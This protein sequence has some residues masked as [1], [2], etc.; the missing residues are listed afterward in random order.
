MLAAGA[1]EELY[2]AGRGAWPGIHADAEAFRARLEASAEPPT[3]AA[4]V[5]L[6][7][8]CAAGDG[9]A[10]AAFEQHHFPEVRRALTRLRIDGASA[11]DI[12]QRVRA[13]VLVGDPPRIA[14]YAG[15]GSLA[16]W[17]R[18]IAV[19]EALTAM[20]AEKRRGPHEGSSA[21]ERIAAPEE[22]ELAQLRARYAGP[23]K[24]AFS[25]A[26]A[27]LGP[28]DRNVLRLTYLEG[29]TAEQIGLAYGVHRVS[30]ARWLSQIRESL[31]ERT[32]ATLRER[33]VL[34]PAE[35]ESVTRL[36]LS[37]IDVSL[38]RLL[39]DAGDE[40]AGG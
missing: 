11:D 34:G 20:R 23:F 8:A 7:V 22:P 17:L 3:S 37:Q 14:T 25:D 16:A 6:A 30:V 2:E 31:F 38:D 18:A 32:H 19:H 12:E 15:R 28:R 36:C 27:S 1:I 21:I 40:E 35:L 5:Y 33:L 26:L 24:T 4:D 39:A 10:L 9:G 29:L 13:K